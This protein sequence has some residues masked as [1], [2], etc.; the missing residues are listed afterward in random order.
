MP[1][2]PMSRRTIFTGLACVGFAAPARAEA[3]SPRALYEEEARPSALARARA[4]QRV[5][6]RGFLAPSPSPEPGWVALAEMP[7]APCTL[8]GLTH[9]WPVGVVA[10]EAGSLPHVPSAF[11]AV[12][13]E[14]VLD[15]APAGGEAAGLPGRVTLRDA[16]L[17][18]A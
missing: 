16:T 12:T 14:G 4:G 1:L 8:C 10:V 9:Q 7:V 3:L 18:A 13:L 11:Q 6:L 15:L 5:A 17:R 2:R